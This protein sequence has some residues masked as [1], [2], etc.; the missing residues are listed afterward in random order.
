M[1]YQAWSVARPSLDAT[2]V[3]STSLVGPLALGALLLATASFLALRHR[4]SAGLFV[5]LG[6]LIPAVTLY[7]LQDIAVPPSLLLVISMTALIL[8]TRRRAA[9]VD[10]K[11]EAESWL[12]KF[13]DGQERRG[14]ARAGPFLFSVNRADRSCM[15]RPSSTSSAPGLQCV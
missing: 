12:V 13:S 3:Y 1:A 10:P 4:A 15:S 5:L 14:P 9:I 2:M 7:A 11:P 8:A 6:Y